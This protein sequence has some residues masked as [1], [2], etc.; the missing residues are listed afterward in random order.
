MDSFFNPT[1]VHLMIT[2][3]SVFGALLGALVLIFAMI[4]KSNQTRTA[5]LLLFI[6]TGLTAF[7]VDPTGDAASHTVKNIAGISKEAVKTH[8]LAAQFGLMSLY[9]LGGASLLALIYITVKKPART[10]AI[11]WII[12]VIALWSFSVTTRT[13]YLGG[14]IR[15]TEL[16]SVQVNS[17]NNM[18][19]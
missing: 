2:H 3:L 1:H 13:A 8:H 10:K 4:T 18:K 19:K 17:V 16:D 15:H 12:L 11:N 14:K 5:A 6:L 7:I 9:I